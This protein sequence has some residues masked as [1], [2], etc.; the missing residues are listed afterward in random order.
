MAHDYGEQMSLMLDGRLTAQESTALEA[1]LATCDACRARWAAFQQVD[2][3]LANAAQAAPAPGFATRLAAR[4]ARESQALDMG[5]ARHARQATRRRVIA[6]IGVFATGA[7]ALVLLVVPML[8]TAWVGI[9][10]LVKGAS[11]LLNSAIAS[12][13]SLLSYWLESVARWLVTLRA[14]GEASESIL[15]VLA[16]SGRPILAGYILMLVAITVAWITVM[17][18]ASGRQNTTTLP[19]LIWL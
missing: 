4:L 12:V 18:S 13:P 14:V 17:R 19:V 10:D 3:V 6:G 9:G 2:R 15:S 11:P 16:H 5:R 7:V 1:H 8:L